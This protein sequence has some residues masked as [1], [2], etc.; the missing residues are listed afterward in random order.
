MTPKVEQAFD[1]K[2]AGS[3]ALTPGQ[4]IRKYC[5]HCVGE[6]SSD[7]PGCDGTDCPF[8]KYRMGKG[9]PPAKVIRKFCLECM[10]GSPH[11]VSEC[12]V[13]DCPCHPYRFGKNLAHSPRPGKSKAWMRSIHPRKRKMMS[14]TDGKFRRSGPD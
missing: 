10:G 14:K 7:V 13:Q 3:I 11:L 4:T 12:H 9:R 8:H 2:N 5:V 1:L 6:V